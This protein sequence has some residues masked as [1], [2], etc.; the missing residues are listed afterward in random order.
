MT[1]LVERGYVDL[2]ASTSAN[3]TEDLLEPARRARSAR[4]TPNT[5]TTPSFA[6][7]ASIGS[8]TTW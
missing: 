3:V 7:R 2:V 1:W 4:S 5:W 8:T 6:A